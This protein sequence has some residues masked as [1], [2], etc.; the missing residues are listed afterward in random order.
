MPYIY[1]DETSF[2]LDQSNSSKII[3]VGVLLTIQP[4]HQNV[5]SDALNNLANDNDIDKYDAKTLKRG[6]FHASE[7]SKNAHSHLCS[8]INKSVNGHFYY[9]YFN[10]GN[11]SHSSKSIS[12]EKKYQSLLALASTNIF[13]HNDE[14]RF[15][16]EERQSFGQTQ[17]K[18]VIES[19][20]SQ[21]LLSTYNQ[22]SFIT[23]YP[24]LDVQVGPKN[25][26]GLQVLDFLL[27]SVN[28]TYRKKK[29]TTWFDRINKKSSSSHT[30]ENSNLE[31]GDFI[32]NDD[33]HFYDSLNYPFRVKDPVGN[34]LYY[35]FEV[36]ETLLRQVAKMEL[37][38][39]VMHYKA[40]LKYLRDEVFQKNRSVTSE[41]L[42]KMC[43]LFIK[44]FD[45]L[46]LYADLEDDNEEA[47][48]ILLTSKKMAGLMIRNELMHSQRTKAAYLNWRNSENVK[49]H[50]S[51]LG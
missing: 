43:M 12:L 5:I 6:C 40:E 10:E 11:S 35:C 9:S 19:L 26:P 16:L 1:S 47:W 38:D 13:S 27:W 31:G 36:I 21:L 8:S 7:D 20:A 25:D 41:I 24:K 4:I 3:G 22:P 17:A 15:L 18:R 28:R 32:M 33:P 14:I 34:D 51:S 46:P 2:Q 30:I 39:L 37:P 29:D 50:M 23:Y 44:L 45:T 48:E 42:E 49:S